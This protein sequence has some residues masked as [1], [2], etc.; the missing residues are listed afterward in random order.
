MDYVTIICTGFSWHCRLDTMPSF[1][2]IWLPCFSISQKQC[3]V[4]SI[5]HK[6]SSCTSSPRNTRYWRSDVLPT[7]LLL[8]F[9]F[10]WKSIVTSSHLEPCDCLFYLSY[11]LPA[12]FF[13]ISS[14]SVL[15]WGVLSTAPSSQLRSSTLGKFTLVLRHSSC[16]CA[17]FLPYFHW[18]KEDSL[19]SNWTPTWNKGHKR[20]WWL[21]TESRQS[22][23]VCWADWGTPGRIHLREGF[24][25]QESA[26]ECSSSRRDGTHV[27]TV[28]K[29]SCAGAG[30]IMTWRGTPPV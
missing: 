29:S 15:S 16:K 9:S 25:Q 23:A 28:P 3:M 10:V 1:P 19:S 18:I 2:L 17:S 8:G 4:I 14:R 13:Q 27:L 5:A 7:E 6:I 24:K 26:N 30:N 12:K 21:M 20:L 11:M 22:L